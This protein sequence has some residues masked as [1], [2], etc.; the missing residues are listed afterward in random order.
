MKS[1]LV[2]VQGVNDVHP[3]SRTLPTAAHQW[4]AVCD[5]MLGAL[6]RQ[7]R[8]CGCNCVY[9]EHD[10]GGDQSI[11]VA[12]SENRVLLTRNSCYEKVRAIFI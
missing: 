8:M 12:L 1:A 4:R 3:E 9:I 2:K 6:A 5:S 7:L 11:K 10:R